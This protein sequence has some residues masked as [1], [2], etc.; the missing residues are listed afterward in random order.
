MIEWHL[1]DL[2]NSLSGKMPHMPHFLE[3]IRL[4]GIRGIRDLQVRFRH[5]VCVLAGRNATG[6]STV[7]F[8]AACAYSVPGSGGRD[9]VPATLFP[10]YRPKFGDRRDERTPISLDFSYSTPTGLQRMRW[11]RMKGWNRSF[12]GDRNAVQPVRRVYLRTLSNLSNP[13]EVRGILSMNR[14]RSPPKEEALTALQL[15]LA[16]RMLPFRYSEVHRLHSGTKSLLFAL[17]KN[18]PAYSELHMAA[19]ER[20]LFR[21]SQA[22][23]HLQDALVLIDEVEAG[24]HPFAQQLLMVQLQQL[25]LRNNIQVIVT[26]HSPV[27]LDCVPSIARIFMERSESGNVYVQEPYRDILQNAFYGRSSQQLKIL[28]EDQA[29]EAILEGVFDLLIPRL[30]MRRDAVVIGRNTGADEF[31]SHARAFRK[32][33]LVDEFVF[34]LDGDQREGAIRQKIADAAETSSVRILYL[35]GDEAPEVWIWTRLSR[36]TNYL[37]GALRQNPQ[38]LASQIRDLNSTFDAASDTKAEIAKAKLRGLS[39]VIRLKPAQIC[40]QVAFAEARR[41]SGDIE[42]LVTD[43]ID[44]VSHW[45]NSN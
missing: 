3:S 18:G 35:P 27:V 25:A 11:R 28:C 26:T 23:G 44:A 12:F 40:Q 39:R 43:L 1:E 45:R 29:A 38:L 34:V 32:F 4:Q 41:D 30:K 6:K 2:W 33:R 36:E 22:I 9:F 13:S 31:A 20:V 21:L 5:P 19:G 10:D 42:P 24:L 15:E 8:G 14:L 37:A 7:L 17:Q 16:Q